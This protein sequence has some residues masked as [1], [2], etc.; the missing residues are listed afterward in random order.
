MTFFIFRPPLAT[1]LTD[2]LVEWLTQS[3]YRQPL[4]ILQ[5][6]RFGSAE[7]GGHNLPLAG[8]GYMGAQLNSKADDDDAKESFSAYLEY[9]KILRTWFVAFGIGGPAIFL[10]NA[11]LAT[12]LSEQGE[13]RWVSSLFLCGA[14]CQVGGAFLNKVVNWYVYESAH[15]EAEKA[16]WQYRWANYLV[17][18]FWIDI[19]LDSLTI[20]F[21]GIA[22]WQLLT[23]FAP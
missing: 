5:F 18:R 12:R 2:R 16:V 1:S 21:F 22:A 8:R 10:A 6:V 19:T 13:L 15:P 9:N 17:E 23:A 3:T 14:A 4:S 11:P 7:T 20:T